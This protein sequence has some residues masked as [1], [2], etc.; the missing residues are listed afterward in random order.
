MA[1]ELGAQAAPREVGELALLAE[2]R[3]PQLGRGDP[4]DPLPPAAGRR[5]RV[6][7][8]QVGVQVSRQQL[9]ERA[10]P[11]QV[12]VWI[13][14]VTPRISCRTT[15][16]HVAFAVLAWRWLT[17]FAPAREA[18]AERGHVELR[19]IAVRPRPISSTRSTGT[20][21]V[22]G[23]PSPSRS[24]PGDSPDE[25]G[26]EALVAGRDRRM[27]REDAV[28]ADPLEGVVQ[29]DAGRDEL[30]GPLGEQER[31]V[32]L[33]EVPGRGLDPERPD[34][35]DAADAQHELLV[36]PHLAARGR[37]AGG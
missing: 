20:P 37:R 35:P 8:V 21:P 14:F 27:D 23:R 25:P 5:R 36:E 3:L 15:P 1:G 24:A 12:G 30:A 16:R 13:P 4:V 9:A 7:V 6:E 2:V 34:R 11:T 33:V 17:A 29:R 22:F 18:E 32:A 10:C 26:V 19:R 31:R 28:A